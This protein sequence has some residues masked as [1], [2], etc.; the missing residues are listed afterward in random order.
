MPI[1][2]LIVLIIAFAPLCA[3]FTVPAIA[4][5][6]AAAKQCRL[7]MTST[8]GGRESFKIL[9]LHGKGDNEEN[10]ARRL[11]PLRQKLTSDRTNVAW[12]FITAPWAL[13][14]ESYAWWTLPPGAPM[15]SMHTFSTEERSFSPSRGAC[16]V[17]VILS[18]FLISMQ[19]RVMLSSFLSHPWALLGMVCACFFE[20]L[21]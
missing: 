20:S 19:I 8:S 3:S 17:V 14:E 16:M 11:A 1:G 10:F 4:S 13:A 5:Y 21:C 12:D 2:A 18:F 6:F 7:H 9:I 15:I